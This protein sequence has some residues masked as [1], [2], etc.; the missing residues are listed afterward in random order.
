VVCG[1]VVCGLVVCGLVVCGLVAGVEPTNHA[2]GNP[3]GAAV[4]PGVWWRKGRFGTPSAAGSH[5]VE[6][7]MTVVATLK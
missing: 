1:L 4:R 3:P 7:M 5:F 6:R 2:A